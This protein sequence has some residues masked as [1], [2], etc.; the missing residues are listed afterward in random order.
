[1]VIQVFVDS[2]PYIPSHRRHLLFNKL[3]AVAGGGNYLWRT[4][5]LMMDQVVAKGTM[6]A[7]LAREEVRDN[8]S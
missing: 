7:E 2:Y 3:L 4:L 1:M 6:K 5:L 8:L